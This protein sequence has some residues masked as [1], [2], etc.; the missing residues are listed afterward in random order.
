MNK[1]FGED[2]H[3][4]TKCSQ[5]TFNDG[6]DVNSFTDNSYLDKCFP[7]APEVYIVVDI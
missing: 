3:N 7:I 2:K 1:D 5:E 4:I 6:L